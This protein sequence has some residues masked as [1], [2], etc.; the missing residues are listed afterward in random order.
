MRE[1]RHPLTNGHHIRRVEHD[2]ILGA[3][4]EVG[5]PSVQGLQGIPVPLEHRLHLLGVATL[6]AKVV[7]VLNRLHW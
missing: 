6:R 2:H 3:V 7:R 1:H 4:R 5:V